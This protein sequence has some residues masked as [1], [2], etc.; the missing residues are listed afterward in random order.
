[1]IGKLGPQ[2]GRGGR[3]NDHLDLFGSGQRASRFRERLTLSRSGPRILLFK[4]VQIRIMTMSRTT[5]SA[6]V[7]SLLLLGGCEMQPPPA[8]PRAPL[9]SEIKATPN[10]AAPAGFQPKSMIEVRKELAAK[11][12]KRQRTRPPPNKLARALRARRMPQLPR[13]PIRK[14]PQPRPMRPRHRR[15]EPGSTRCPTNGLS[16]C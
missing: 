13:V 8:A 3:A 4:E 7:S 12:A 15:P 5:R 6:L 11:K 10:V 14:Q 9:P 16:R 2:I 1:M